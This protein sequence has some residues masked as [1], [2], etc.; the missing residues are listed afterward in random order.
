[1]PVYRALHQ[2]LDD[3]EPEMETGDA[4]AD[5]QEKG[6]RSRRCIPV[7]IREEDGH[8]PCEAETEE[9]ADSEAPHST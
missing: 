3:T 1:M 9:E 4:L 5:R 8:T 6:T 7:H 2:D